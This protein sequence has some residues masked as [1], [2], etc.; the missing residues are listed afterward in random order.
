MSLSEMTF[1]VVFRRDITYTDL[2]MTSK[3]HKAK[4]AKKTRGTRLA[5]RLRAEGNKLTDDQREQLGE[6]FMK[7][8]YGG[9]S[10]RV[11]THRR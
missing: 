11:A 6:E 2:V 7:L 8:Y 3:S 4:P 9:E 5:E 10:R 1:E